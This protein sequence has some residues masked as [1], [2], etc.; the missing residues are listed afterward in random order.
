MKVHLTGTGRPESYKTR[1]KR[2][3]GAQCRKMLKFQRFSRYMTDAIQN[4]GK[5]TRNLGS[6]TQFDTSDGREN[7][8]MNIKRAYS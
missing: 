6:R 8:M 2:K 5:I 3:F 7:S 1:L 4:L